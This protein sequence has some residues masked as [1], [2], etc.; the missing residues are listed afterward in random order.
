[1]DIPARGR[2]VKT[3]E[4]TNQAQPGPARSG[5][6]GGPPHHGI[7]ILEAPENPHQVFLPG[8][9]GVGKKSLGVQSHDSVGMRNGAHEVCLTQCP[10][11]AKS[12]VDVSLPQ[13][14]PF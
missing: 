12:A 9:G 6:H 11:P 8:K 10:E 2:M 5:L 7:G 14:V 3:Q 4:R 1:M 13:A